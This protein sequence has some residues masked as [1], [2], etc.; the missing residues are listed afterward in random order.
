MIDT[1]VIVDLLEGDGRWYEWSREALTDAR[2]AGSVIASAIVLGE[3][4][5][6]AVGFE[7]L[8]EMLASFGVACS[9][10]SLAAA[11]RAGLAHMAYRAAGGQRE[12]L[13]G[14]FLIG[15]HAETLHAALLTRD[16]RRYRHYFPDLTL[17][18][19]ETDNG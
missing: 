1:N 6:R 3:L 12:K 13:L 7:E 16:P 18:T 19:P 11:H 17:I 10:L 8:I 5:N 14:D 4:A 15:A 2:V 9:D